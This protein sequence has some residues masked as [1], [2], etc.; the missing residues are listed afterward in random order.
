MMEHLV[1]QFLFLIQ[2]DHFSAG[3]PTSSMLARK[4]AYLRVNLVCL[5]LGVSDFEIYKKVDESDYERLVIKTGYS[6]MK[7]N[8]DCSHLVSGCD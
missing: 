8:N 7:H 1:S 3:A 6:M 5:V 4:P 2:E